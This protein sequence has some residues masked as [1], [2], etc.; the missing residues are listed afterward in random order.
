MHGYAKL[1]SRSRQITIVSRP[2]V[3]KY[4]DSRRLHVLSF[5]GPALWPARR[6]ATYLAVVMPWS[7]HC[8]RFTCDT[9][10]VGHSR[11]SYL[12]RCAVFTQFGYEL[13]LLYIAGLLTLAASGTT[14]TSQE[15][16]IEPPH[17]ETGARIGICTQ[18]LDYEIA[19]ATGAFLIC[20][21]R[22]AATLLRG[23]RVD[24]VA[25]RK[26]RPKL[27]LSSR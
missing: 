9:G 5:G 13:N 19:R 4:T 15:I 11:S 2:W 16:A 14:V 10:L 26:P 3:F 23:A 1:T 27:S 7:W 8:L 21:E 25:W 12:V 18:W 24:S 6:F 22:A 20:L 17:A